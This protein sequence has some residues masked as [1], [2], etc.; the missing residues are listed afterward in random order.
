MTLYV[1]DNLNVAPTE[2]VEERIYFWKLFRESSLPS[3]WL[4]ITLMS[5]LMLSKAISP[6]LLKK[7]EYH[8]TFKNDY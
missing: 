8:R 2:E 6:V 1:T 5:D 4:L 3:E 7:E